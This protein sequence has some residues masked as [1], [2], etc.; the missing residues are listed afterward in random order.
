M[1]PND[2]LKE[3]HLS[4]EAAKKLKNRAALKKEISSG[5]TAQ[6]ILGFTDSA[7]DAFY[8]AAETLLNGR[9]YD[10]ALNAFL[11]LITMNP[12]HHDYWI[13][14]GMSVQMVGDYQSAL[15]AYEIAAMYE[16]ENPIPY[17]Q[18]AKCFMEL[19]DRENTREAFLL[20]I[21]YAGD[22]KKYASLKKEAKK[23]LKLLDD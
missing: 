4:K 15:D 20:V 17:F 8:R 2:G 6:E 10:D 12:H 16:V 1:N 18:L 19:H 5:K 9:R 11:F 22:S 7:M 14:L 23:A 3:F 13:G 21:E